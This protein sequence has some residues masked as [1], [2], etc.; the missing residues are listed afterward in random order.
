M[1]PQH[2]FRTIVAD[3]DPAPQRERDRIS[4]L[5]QKAADRPRGFVCSFLGRFPQ[6][7]ACWNKHGKQESHQMK[8]FCNQPRG[9]L[10]RKFDHDGKLKMSE[11]NNEGELGGTLGQ[12]GVP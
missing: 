6:S 4:G 8:D 1:R 3:P 7:C 2:Q 9:C 11:L 10:A 5:P 12:W